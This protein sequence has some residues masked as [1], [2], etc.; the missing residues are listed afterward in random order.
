MFSK[1]KLEKKV[2]Q[3]IDILERS[4]IREISYIIGSRKEIVVRNIIAGI[5]RG[6]GIG[7][8]NNYYNS[9]Y[10]IFIAKNSYIKYSCNRRVC[11]RYCRDSGKK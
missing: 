8:R 9:Y 11:G 1:K 3:L 5:S 2:E 10:S 4:N 7:L 6:V